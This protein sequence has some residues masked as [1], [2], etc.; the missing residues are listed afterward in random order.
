M[1]YLRC[2]RA[3]ALSSIEPRKSNETTI[4]DTNANEAK[5]TKYI[6]ASGPQPI[7]ESSFVM[8]AVTPFPNATESR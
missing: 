6:T 2:Y 7:V 8:T 3:S 4:A 1:Q 5:V